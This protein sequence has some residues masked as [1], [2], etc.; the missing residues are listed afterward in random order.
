MA[1]ITRSQAEQITSAYENMSD[2]SVQY[3]TVNAN[4][5]V[6]DNTM[7]AYVEC[8]RGINIFINIDGMKVRVNRV[9]HCESDDNQLT[10]EGINGYIVIEISDD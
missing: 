8:F 5:S 6:S 2:I 10:I 1:K 4:E 9:H 7:F 3:P